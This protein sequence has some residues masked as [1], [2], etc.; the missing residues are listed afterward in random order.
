MCLLCL[1]LL[2]G[3]SF[4]K[5]RPPPLLACQLVF[6]TMHHFRRWLVSPSFLTLT[7]AC[8]SAISYS[9]ALLFSSTCV[10]PSHLTSFSAAMSLNVCNVSMPSSLHSG[11]PK[12]VDL[13]LCLWLPVCQTPLCLAGMLL[14]FSF[15]T[16]GSL[17]FSEYI[18]VSAST[19]ASV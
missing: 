1:A 13:N 7:S 9:S 14:T 4:V 12:C 10:S 19:L 17:L 18:S 3:L 2:L 5:S 15:F 6:L 16:T 11:P 8:L